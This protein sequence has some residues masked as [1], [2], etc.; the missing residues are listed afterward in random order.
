MATAPSSLTWS[1]A[2]HVETVIFV[3]VDGVLNV[4]A[5]D[6]GDAPLL[7]NQTNIDISLKVW[8]NHQHHAQRVCIEKMVAVAQRQLGH[9]EDS[10]Y[11]KFACSNT[12]SVSEE[13]AK[14]LATIVLAAGD[15][16]RVAVVLSSNWRKMQ[17]AGRVRK[18]EETVSRYMG[19]Q[20]FAF[21]AK[22]PNRTEQ[23]AADRLESVGDF[24][25]ELS[26]QRSGLA[27]PLKALLLEDFFITAM[28][29][30]TCGGVSMNSVADAEGY[31]V[32][33]ASAVKAR[34]V[35]CYDQWTTSSGLEVRVGGGLTLQRV[36]EAKVFLRLDLEDPVDADENPER[37]RSKEIPVSPI[38]ERTPFSKMFGSERRIASKSL[39]PPAS[40]PLSPLSEL[41]WPEY[42]SLA[43]PWVQSA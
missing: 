39:T 12:S 33:R 38:A 22:T 43:L 8:G 35:H 18:L 17:H 36:E 37:T 28:D 21:D 4:G 20:S 31:L 19:G 24:L 26:N 1:Q 6:S 7:L 29:G 14:R 41:R 30:W 42:F 23:L 10:T 13:L 11:A 40:P 34:I 3:D 27:T 16:D 32:S 2:R 25:A 5:Q 9:G 15:R